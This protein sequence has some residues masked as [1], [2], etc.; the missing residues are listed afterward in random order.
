ML[1]KTSGNK[2]GGNYRCILCGLDFSADN[3]HQFFS[4]A[5]VIS[6]IPKSISHSVH[7]FT[8]SCPSNDS[9]K[10]RLGYKSIA[11]L[12]S[13]I[14]PEERKELMSTIVKDC[15][16]S[17]DNLHNVK[18]HL[19]KM[20]DLERER[21]DFNDG[22]FLSNLNEHLGRLSTAGTDMNGES[23]RKLAI[24]FEKII[25]PCVAEGRTIAFSS[26]YHNWLE[27]QFLMY[28]FGGLVVDEK[29]SSL[30]DGVKTR[31]H[32][33]TFIH[34]QQV[35]FFLLFRFTL[36]SS[37][38]QCFFKKIY[39]LIY[40]FV[41]YVYIYFA[42]YI[43]YIFYILISRLDLY[44]ARRFM[45]FIFILSQHT[46]LLLLKRKEASEIPL[47]RE[48]NLYLPFSKGL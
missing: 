43:F 36:F 34:L 41:Y 6:Q 11:G 42:L 40:I 21:P 22:L 30:L 31:M 45:I 48:E 33:C 9:L 17:I 16:P 13:G 26:L 27:I 25:L 39:L 3:C 7:L 15:A 5:H 1:Q 24:L 44:M 19:S 14:S 4:Y 10:E 18:G 8:N 35:C 29:D 28:D 38:S 2:N 47:P 37:F 20:I 23:H 46:W 32:L 12:Y